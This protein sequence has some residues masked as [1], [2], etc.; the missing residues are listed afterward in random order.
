MTGPP[1]SWFA[2]FDSGVFD[3]PLP[4][5]S[6][7]V[8]TSAHR[9]SPPGRR[10]RH[11]AAQDDQHVLP[12]RTTSARSRWSDPPGTMLCSSVGAPRASHSPPARRSRHLPGSAQG[13]RPP[14]SRSTSPGLGRRRRFS[15][16]GLAVGAHTKQAAQ[17]RDSSASIGATGVHGRAGA[18]P[19]LT[20]RHPTSSGTGANDTAPPPEVAG[21]AVVD[22]WTGTLRRPN[23]GMHRF[24]LSEAGL[25]TLRIAGQTSGRRTE[26]AHSSSPAR[27]MCCR[28]RCG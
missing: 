19:R 25:G 11:R 16:F 13:L 5:P 10:G 23:P 7:E 8:S 20:I 15:G 6:T 3:S 17:D 22:R 27:A 21:V 12:C 28:A 26:L 24:T 4:T 1:D 9:R 18:H 2:L 14:G